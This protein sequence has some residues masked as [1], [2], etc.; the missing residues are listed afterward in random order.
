MTE[1]ISKQHAERHLEAL[2]QSRV[3]QTGEAYPEAWAN[4]LDTEEGALYYALGRRSES[5]A[6]AQRVAVGEQA[7]IAKKLSQDAKDALFETLRAEAVRMFPGLS[8]P[9][10]VAKYLQT[11]DGKRIWSAYDDATNATKRPM[12]L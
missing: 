7:T 4:V 12:K 3:A 1:L 8:E 11:E 6:E 2:V 5:R 10:A 9:E